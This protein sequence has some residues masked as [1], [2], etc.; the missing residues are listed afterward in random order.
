MNFT[1]LLQCFILR[2]GV[3]GESILIIEKKLSNV[4]GCRSYV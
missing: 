3:L 2:S 1:E 4:L